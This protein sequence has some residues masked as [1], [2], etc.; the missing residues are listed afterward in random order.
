MHSQHVLYDR[1]DLEFCEY[2]HVEYYMLFPP[3]MMD[4]GP[5]SPPDDMPYL[6]PL[7]R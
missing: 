1:W 7:P 2:C 5:S 3:L 4:T 6:N